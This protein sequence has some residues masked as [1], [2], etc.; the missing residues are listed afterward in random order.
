MVLMTES[1]RHSA[2]NN[3]HKPHELIRT[4]WRRTLSFRY[5]KSED[6]FAAYKGVRT[7]AI[8]K[9]TSSLGIMI[10]EGRHAEVGQGIFISDIQEGSAAEM[11]GLQIGDM[12]LAVNKDSL[13]GC[14]YDSA[15][16]TLKRTEGLV[17][18]TIC[19]PN[20]KD[21]S[22]NEEGSQATSTSASRPA[23]RNQTPDPGLKTSGASRPQTPKPI[24][25]PVKAEP[26]QDPATAKI[27]PNKETVIEITT[28]NQSLG[29]IVLGGSDTF[30]NGPAA[31]ILEVYPKGAAGKDGRLQ[32]GDQIRECGGIAINKDMTHERICLTI[33]QSVPKIKMTVFRPE[34]VQYEDVEVELTRKPGKGLGLCLMAKTPA[35]GVYISDLSTGGSAD[36]DGR[37]QKGDILISVDGIDLTEATHETAAAFL[38]LAS[39]RAS[40]RVKRH[41]V[42]R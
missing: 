17:K 18:L 29:I 19:N 39:T 41:K 4:L 42:V 13:V 32:P 7:V 40:V 31:I 34:P 8:R 6:Q 38:K 12:I 22:P 5:K 9:G 30:I 10:I 26:P 28:Q 35:P 37:L 23:S 27:I 14:G 11:A 21:D 1:R 25:S 20:K 3:F 36:L 33:K 15:A 24:P 2:E 16:A